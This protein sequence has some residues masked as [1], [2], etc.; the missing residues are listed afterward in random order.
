MVF[1]FLIC[2]INFKTYMKKTAL[3]LVIVNMI[4]ECIKKCEAIH[5]TALISSGS[6]RGIM[7]LNLG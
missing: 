7:D 2:I 4:R 3:F 6:M 1:H 5:A